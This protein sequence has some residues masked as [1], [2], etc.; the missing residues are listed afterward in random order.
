M[1]SSCMSMR[2]ALLNTLYRYGN[3]KHGTARVQYGM[4]RVKIYIL[5]G[6]VFLFALLYK[7]TS[8]VNLYLNKLHQILYRYSKRL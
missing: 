5:R 6:T 4:S 2:A 8:Y 3:G 1:L 7:F